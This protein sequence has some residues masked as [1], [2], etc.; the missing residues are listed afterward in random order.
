MTIHEGIHL[1][2]TAFHLNVCP[3]KDVEASSILPD[4]P[5]HATCRTFLLF[6]A[7]ICMYVCQRLYVTFTMHVTL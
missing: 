3:H 1:Y 5:E 6:Y 4:Y 7:L 2:N